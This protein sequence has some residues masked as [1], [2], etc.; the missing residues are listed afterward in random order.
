MFFSSDTS[1]EGRGHA[2]FFCDLDIGLLP[3]AFFC[4]NHQ[5]QLMGG[6]TSGEMPVR[7][8]KNLLAVRTSC[9][10]AADRQLCGNDLFTIEN[11]IPICA[12]TGHADIVLGN[13]RP[14]NGAG[15]LVLGAVAGD[16]LICIVFHLDATDSKVNVLVLLANIFRFHS[17]FP[18]FFSENVSITLYF[19]NHNKITK[20]I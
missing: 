19:G 18:F 14:A 2:H 9:L 13:F 8:G 1:D 11:D 16:D 6:K 20:K 3:T 15:D 12:G 5:H 17:I 10:S 4:R 7:Y